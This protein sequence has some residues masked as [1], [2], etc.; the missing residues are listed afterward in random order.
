MDLNDILTAKAMDIINSN[1]ESLKIKY[2]LYDYMTIEAALKR[3]AD[4]QFFLIEDGHVTG[5]GRYFDS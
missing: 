1:D 2:H 4:G 5:V 3:N